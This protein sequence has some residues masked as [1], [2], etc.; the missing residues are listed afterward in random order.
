MTAPPPVGPYRRPLPGVLGGWAFSYGR[1]A[2]EALA[3]AEPMWCVYI[4]VKGRDARVRLP[5]VGTAEGARSFRG[6]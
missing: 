4:H 6:L 5:R 3:R 1:G 2:P